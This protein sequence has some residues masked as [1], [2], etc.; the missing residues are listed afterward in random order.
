MATDGATT[1]AFE[2]AKKTSVFDYHFGD[3]TYNQRMAPSP[4]FPIFPTQQEEHIPRHG[5][6]SV[7]TQHPVAYK[8]VA[9]MQLFYMPVSLDMLYCITI[10]LG[11][12]SHL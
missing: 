1:F 3:D 9:I 10:W 2:P 7:Q 11:P 8:T 5:M 6:G 12:A 4:Q